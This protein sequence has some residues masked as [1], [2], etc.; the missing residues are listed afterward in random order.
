MNPAIAKLKSP[1]K[2]EEVAHKPCGYDG[3]TDQGIKQKKDA[4]ISIQRAEASSIDNTELRQ[5]IQLKACEV[6]V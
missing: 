1:G 5:E 2:T 6:Y 4:Y 3:F